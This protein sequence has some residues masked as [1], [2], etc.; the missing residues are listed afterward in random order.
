MKATEGLREAYGVHLWL[1]V[2]SPRGGWIVGDDL[3]AWA[4]RNAWTYR[5]AYQGVTM[6]YFALTDLDAPFDVGPRIH[7]STHYAGVKVHGRQFLGAALWVLGELALP[8]LRASI[9]VG[10]GRAIRL[11]EWCGFERTSNDGEV[12]NGVRWRWQPGATP[13][14]SQAGGPERPCG[15]SGGGPRTAAPATPARP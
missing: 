4:R 7:I 2:R 11:A 15:D 3:V 1:L 12:W 10:A 13:A 5:V 8:V 14:G 9:P 6:G